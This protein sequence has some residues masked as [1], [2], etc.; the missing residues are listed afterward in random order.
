MRF[1]LFVGGINGAIAVTLG[2]V[3]AHVLNPSLAE[4]NRSVFETA[5]HYHVVHSLALLMVATLSQH[6]PLD[7]GRRRLAAAG[8]AFLVGIVLFCGG[9]YALSAFGIAS[10]ANVAPFGGMMLI[11]GWLLVASAAFSR[12]TRRFS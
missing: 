2:A 9:L 7:S 8:A 4:A 12:R 10:G 11:A 6:I 3:G 1:W 5:V